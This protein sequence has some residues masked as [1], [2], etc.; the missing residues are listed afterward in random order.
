MKK[1]VIFFCL[2]ASMAFNLASQSLPCGTLSLTQEEKEKLP[3]YGNNNIL[4]KFRDS[5]ES[6]SYKRM[7]EVTSELFWI[8]VRL[9]YFRRADGTGTE[10]NDARCDLV[11]KRV[12]AVLKSNDS[13]IRLYRIC[14]P[15]N[16]YLDNTL[17]DLEDEPFDDV[18]HIFH[19]Y[20][21]AIYFNIHFVNSTRTF[22]GLSPLFKFCCP[23]GRPNNQ[24]IISTGDY[25]GDPMINGGR[26]VYDDDILAKVILHELG[27]TLG[28]HHTHDN[29]RGSSDNR[30]ASICKQEY[31]ARA[32]T[33]PLIPCIANAGNYA[34]EVNGDLLLDTEAD[35]GL[36]IGDIIFVDNECNF[37]TTTLGINYPVLADRDGSVWRP[38]ARNIMS[39]SRDACRNYLSPFQNLVMLMAL[40]HNDSGYGFSLGTNIDEY[41]SDN[42]ILSATATR[43]EFFE[44]QH[45]TIHAKCDEDWVR[46]EVGYFR[47]MVIET[48]AP[49]GMSDPSRYADTQIELY[50]RDAAGN[51]VLIT[52][53][54]NSGTGNFSKIEMFLPAGTYFVRV[55]DQTPNLTLPLHY[56]IGVFNEFALWG[57][58]SAGGAG[59]SAS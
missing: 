31:V 24:T 8:P 59:N 28:L 55:T 37:T 49:F 42:G 4:V 35:P 19:N 46:F 25:L 52:S 29:A 15:S 11:L 38:N 3:F 1:T 30:D 39:Y 32:K 10:I 7:S 57:D 51:P 40:H 47:K 56:L 58:E 6:S 54:D 16:T 23:Y 34:A 20:A 50:S 17:A 33:L 5:L 22:A 26:R 41:E 2:I 43:P 36:R 14:A 44:R 27:H 21:Q 53:D 45:H 18:Q 13:K 9:N 48:R 12:N